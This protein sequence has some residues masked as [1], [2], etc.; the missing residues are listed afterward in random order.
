MICNGKRVYNE[1][2]EDKFGCRLGSSTALSKPALLVI[3][4][5]V[6]VA[7]LVAFARP[8]GLTLE[9][10]SRFKRHQLLYDEAS[11]VPDCWLNEERHTRC[12]SHNR[13]IM[14]HLK[15]SSAF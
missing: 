5:R 4:D 3:S 11:P 8:V 1:V 13:E 2:L 10:E 12:R 7:S 15:G 6:Q 14:N 9:R